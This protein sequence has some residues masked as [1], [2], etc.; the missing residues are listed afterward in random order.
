MT[1][2]EV[3]SRIEEIL[4]TFPDERLEEVLAYLVLIQKISQP[5]IKHGDNLIRILNE[6]KVLLQKLAK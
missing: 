4:D 6:D 1:K 5:N 3:K 2:R